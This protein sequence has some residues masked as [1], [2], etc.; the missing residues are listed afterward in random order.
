MVKHYLDF[1]LMI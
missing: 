1:S